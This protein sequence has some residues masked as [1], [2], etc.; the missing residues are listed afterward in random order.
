MT[1]LGVENSKVV[2]N[3]GAV[4]ASVETSVVISSDK[5]VDEISVAAVE[6][7]S[8]DEKD[9]ADVIEFV[10]DVKSASKVK[11]SVGAVSLATDVSA[12]VL[13]KI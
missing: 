1:T 5:V 8:E 7:I 2:E 13:T 11:K 9:R 10:S 4:D 6:E 3:K 12:F